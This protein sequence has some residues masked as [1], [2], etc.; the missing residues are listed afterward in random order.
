MTRSVRVVAALLPLVPAIPWCG[1]GARVSA[2]CRA[3]QRPC[4]GAHQPDARG[5]NEPGRGRRDAPEDVSQQRRV[6]VFETK[7]TDCEADAR[8]DHEKAG[9]HAGGSAQLHADADCDANDIRTRQELCVCQA[10]DVETL[11]FFQPPVT[12][13]RNPARP[14]NAAAKAK[15]GNGEKPQRGR[16]VAQLQADCP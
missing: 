14:D 9:E 12:L 5:D 1:S 8:R 11:V 2:F 6:S 15:H 4:W 3:P 13:N 16:K 10:H 7:D